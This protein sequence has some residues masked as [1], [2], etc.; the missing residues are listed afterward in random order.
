[1]AHRYATAG[2]ALSPSFT[3][4]LPPGWARNTINTSI[5]RGAGLVTARGVQF[6][7]YYESE[8]QIL[9]IRRDLATNQVDMHRL[10]IEATLNDAHNTISLG[11]D[12]DGYLHLVFEQH[13]SALNYRRSCEPLA[14]DV[15]GEPTPMTGQYE[16]RVTYPYFVTATRP[17]QPLLFLYRNGSAMKAD[18]HLKRY[19][20]ATKTWQDSETP[21]LSG[22]ELRPW[23]AGPYLNHPTVDA[24]GHLHLFF[25]W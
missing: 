15:W 3:H 17:D 8:T 7:A 18:I 12:G 4:Q 14:I 10:S 23:A 25:T 21:L 20:A 16:D 24:R 22:S 9:I 11:V 13:G 6:G 5:F 2:Q 19:D 1:M